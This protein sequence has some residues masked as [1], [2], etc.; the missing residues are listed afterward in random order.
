MAD[1]ADV[2]RSSDMSPQPSLPS[3]QQRRAAAADHHFDVLEASARR[4]T[5]SSVATDNRFDGPAVNLPAGDVSN[6]VTSDAPNLLGPE[7]LQEWVRGAMHSMFQTHG[8]TIWLVNLTAPFCFKMSIHHTVDILLIP[9]L[10]C[11]FQFC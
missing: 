1:M 8:V 4:L 6:Y 11:R 7:D 2:S 5:V 9:A 10:S 3:Q